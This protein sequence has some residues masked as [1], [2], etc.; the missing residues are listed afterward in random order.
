MRSL[1]L[2]LALCAGVLS[3]CSRDALDVNRRA[4]MFAIGVDY[5]QKAHDYAV[6]YVFSN[7]SASQGGS[8][9]GMG[10]SSGS[11]EAPLIVRT[12]MG[13]TVEDAISRLE[14]ELPAQVFYGGTRMLI[15]GDGLLRHGARD[16]IYTVAALHEMP[17]RAYVA[18]TRE[19]AAAFL[20]S[21]EVL[22]QR[23]LYSIFQSR[24]TQNLALRPGYLFSSVSHA[25]EARFA[26]LLPLFT[27]AQQ[28]VDFLGQVVLRG[29]LELGVVPE[30]D[31][32]LVV[33]LVTSGPQVYR[34]DLPGWSRNPVILGARSAK[35]TVSTAP[36]GSVLVRLHL[37]GF[38][39]GRALLVEAGFSD[40]ALEQ[41]IGSELAA[42]L[43]DRLLALAKA[44]VDPRALA[45]APY[46]H[47]GS[48]VVHTDVYVTLDR[49]QQ[50]S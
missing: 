46:A 31:A 32:S 20:S 6:T 21:P 28:R 11:A 49:N 19:D 5:D 33:P 38:V 26:A 41:R 29:G 47:T 22:K 2:A 50:V 4:L 13:T 40:A 45:D 14:D 10:A 23:P 44:G 3:G 39:Y 36:D 34:V 9:G 18:A 37:L 8:S 43:T 30:S 16:A 27:Y 35:A 17:W 15:L 25:S 42:R 48:L 7:L 24:A 12:E 1:L